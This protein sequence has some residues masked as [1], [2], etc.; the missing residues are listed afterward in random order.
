MRMTG[1]P[2]SRP[3]SSNAS[4]CESLIT[5]SNSVLSA[6]SASDAGRPASARASGIVA[7]SSRRPLLWKRVPMAVY[8]GPRTP[9]PLY[10]AAA[11]Q[12][13]TGPQA[14]LIRSTYSSLSPLP[15]C[16]MRFR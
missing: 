7:G 16:W 5:W 15:S 11:A 14:R 4:L 12:T 1:V 10:W 6:A 8:S 3:T 9:G 13:R 2:T